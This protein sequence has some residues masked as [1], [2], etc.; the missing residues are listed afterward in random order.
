LA[1]DFK[2]QRILD[3]T[4]PSAI[5]SAELATLATKVLGT[6]I[7]SVSVTTEELQRRM[8]AS[9]MPEPLARVLA[10]IDRGVSQGAMDVRSDAFQQLTGRQ[11]MSVATFIS[12]HRGALAGPQPPPL[13][14]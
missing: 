7:V 3:I 1:A 2:G 13:P 12:A 6:S 5:T 14:S 9:G 10:G 8:V 11:P 4:G